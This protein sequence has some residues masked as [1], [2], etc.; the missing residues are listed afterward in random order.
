MCHDM[1]GASERAGLALHFLLIP[2]SHTSPLGHPQFV[3][4]GGKVDGGGADYKD[5]M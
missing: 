1:G 3:R 2:R 4:E 5:A